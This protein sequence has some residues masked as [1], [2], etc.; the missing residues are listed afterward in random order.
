MKPKPKPKLPAG[1]EV[2]SS[3]NRKPPKR[4][5]APQGI[6]WWKYAIWVFVL[7]VLTIAAFV[8]WQLLGI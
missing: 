4:R 3:S 6:A 1:W 5:G 8:P 7:T 2:Y